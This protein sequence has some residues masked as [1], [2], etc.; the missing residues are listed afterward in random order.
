MFFCVKGIGS[1]DK[2]R[3]INKPYRIL[4]SDTEQLFRPN[5][6][7]GHKTVKELRSECKIWKEYHQTDPKSAQKIC[8]EKFILPKAKHTIVVPM[9]EEFNKV[10]Y[11][12][13][14]HTIMGELKKDIQGIHFLSDL[15]PAIKKYTEKGH[16][17]RNGVW[18]ADITYHCQRRDKT[19]KK[20]NSTMFPKS[21]D[22][23]RFIFEVFHAYNNRSRCETNKQI[24]HSVTLS[25]IPVDFIIKN[26]ELRT[27][28]PIYQDEK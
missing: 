15:N 26:N 22:P 2:H 7:K 8:E 10:S 12:L 11:K 24:Y 25:G 18:L 16:E 6:C 17:D 4:E 21:W 28:Y 3:R 27:V 19:Y 5:D 20:Q 9:S 13:I 14:K 23:T 1:D